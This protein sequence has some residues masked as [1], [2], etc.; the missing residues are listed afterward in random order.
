MD[1]RKRMKTRIQCP[2]EYLPALQKFVNAAVKHYNRPDVETVRQ[3]KID[4]DYQLL[5]DGFI[6]LN[7]QGVRLMTLELVFLYAAMP[8]DP[9]GPAWRGFLRYLER[10]N[11]TLDI[12]PNQPETPPETAITAP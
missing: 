1:E 4:E 2:A 12:I 10:N 5:C 6:F 11:Y 8:Q 7:D 9:N 3:S